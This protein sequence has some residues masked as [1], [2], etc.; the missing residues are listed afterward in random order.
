VYDLAIVRRNM[1][2]VTVDVDDDF[3]VLL[4]TQTGIYF[5]LNRV[6]LRIWTLASEPISVTTISSVLAREY[7]I[8]NARCEADVARFV[9]EL[10]A[11]GLV[12][13]VDPERPRLHQS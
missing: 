8:E 4:Q 6:S 9:G 10:L 11:A 1:A 7:G 2:D 13:P 3:A 12:T 5:E